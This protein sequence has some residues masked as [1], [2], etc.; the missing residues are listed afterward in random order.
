MK[1]KSDSELESIH[2]C[3]KQYTLDALNA[4]LIE[5]RNRNLKINN[6]T[7]IEKWVKKLEIQKFKDSLSVVPKLTWG[8]I[9][10]KNEVINLRKFLGLEIF[11]QT[12]VHSVTPKP[13]ISKA[14]TEFPTL[15]LLSKKEFPRGLES[16]TNNSEWRELANEI[17]IVTIYN[18]QSLGVI[19]IIA[20]QDEFSYL[21]LIR[22]Y[23]ESISVKLLKTNKTGDTLSDLIIN[24]LEMLDTNKESDYNFTNVLTLLINNTIGKKRVHFPEKKFIINILKIY[25]EKNKFVDISFSKS[26]LGLI[27]NYSLIL[28]ESEKIKL[29]SQYENSERMKIVSK[30][31]TD[32]DL[33]IFCKI[34]KYLSDEF[35]RHQIDTG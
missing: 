26:N 19:S 15:C 16:I 8:S 5:V 21:G 32:I 3:Y 27:S 6:T 14:F 33:F 4:Y 35:F 18:L 29:Q 23:R 30:E 7:E 17:I 34:K 12:R 20:F 1:S 13:I 10:I 2:L 28:D 25:S 9:P 24:V 31:T 11:V 22:F